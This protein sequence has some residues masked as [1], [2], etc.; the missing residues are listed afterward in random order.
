MSV[1]FKRYKQTYTVTKCSQSLDN[2]WLQSITW[3]LHIS[4]SSISINNNSIQ[5]QFV[6]DI[7]ENIFI[8]VFIWQMI[9]EPGNMYSL[10][11]SKTE[12]WERHLLTGRYKCSSSWRSRKGEKWITSKSINSYISGDVLQRSGTL[13]VNCFTTKHW[14]KVDGTMTDVSFFP[15]NCKFARRWGYTPTCWA[16]P[17]ALR[18]ARWLHQEIGSSTLLSNCFPDFNGL[19]L[20]PGAEALWRSECFSRCSALPAPPIQRKHEGTR[21]WRSP[22]PAYR[23]AATD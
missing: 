23:R 22:L 13:L 9:T 3:L 20:S 8:Y 21:L 19:H 6:K 12:D 2:P 18:R 17:S 11:S 15:A 7:T 1:S 14:T 4:A 5:W 10:V 16:T